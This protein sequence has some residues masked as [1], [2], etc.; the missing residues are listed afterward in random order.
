M[1]TVKKP[2]PAEGSGDTQESAAEWLAIDT[3]RGWEQNPRKHGATVP[4][5]V[6]AIIRYG[7]GSPIEA[8]AENRE[9]IAGHGRMQ[10]AQR[11]VAKWHKASAARRGRW[12]P[13]AKRVGETGEIP[14]R[15]RDLDED[16][17]HQAALA[18]NRIGQ[19]SAWDEDLLAE[20]LE[21]FEDELDLMG[22]D[23]KE[24]ERLLSED[25]ALTDGDTAP[26]LRD[27]LAY[28]V[29][30]KCKSEAH[31]SEVII[32]LEAEGLECKP[33]IS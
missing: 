29:L 12:H 9:I 27:G 3:L 2:R 5:L 8:R 22:F 28:Q 15:L 33:L 25:D 19:E 24:A 6:R 31:Q 4:K 32:R 13:E 26:K 23:D 7:W 18:D 20:Q 17:A 1:K 21:E 10:A 16:D 14:V 30:V 11:L